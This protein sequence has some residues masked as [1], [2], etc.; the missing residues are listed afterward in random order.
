M[1]EREVIVLNS[2]PEAEHE[3]LLEACVRYAIISLPFTTNRMGISS[4]RQRILNIAKGKIAEALYWFFCKHNQIR[5]DFK[6]CAT[7]FWDV[8]KRDFLL[9]GY[10]W[11]IKNNFIYHK[12]DHPGNYVHLPA[13]IPNRFECD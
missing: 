8:Y 12:G 10:E 1:I 7:E 9:N 5:P 11:D 13:L 3:N 2:I 6:S 4:E